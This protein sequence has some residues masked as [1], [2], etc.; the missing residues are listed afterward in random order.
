[1]SAVIRKDGVLSRDGKF[2]WS[3][4]WGQWVPS[5]REVQ[6]E[7]PAPLESGPPLPQRHSE[8]CVCDACMTAG[9]HYADYI[10]ARG[11]W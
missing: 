10:K 11:L 8:S 7:A 9:Q 3:A 2:R 4:G 1:M 6:T 5:G